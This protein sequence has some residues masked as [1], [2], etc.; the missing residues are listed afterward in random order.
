MCIMVKNFIGLHVN[1][2]YSIGRLLGLGDKAI[3]AVIGCGGKTTLISSLAKEYRQKKVLVT[4][5]T[6]IFP[7]SGED[8]TL[9]TIAQKCLSHVP[10]KGIQCLGVLNETT[11]KLEALQQEQLEKII[12]QYDLVL[13]E[14]DGSSGLPCKAWLDYEPVIPSYCTHTIGVVTLNALGKAAGTDSVHRL[15]EFLKLTCLSPDEAISMQALS[16]MVCAE[17]GMFKRSIGKQCIFVNQAEDEY[18][19]LAAANWLNE[20][21]TA[22]PGRFSCLAY[23]SALKNSWSEV[24]IKTAL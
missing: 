18:S 3:I 15:P 10:L 7:M 11:G 8:I 22:N 9:L 19:S 21:Q 23:G 24:C 20:I 5:T 1:E 14:A 16:A 13:L 6:K 2:F 12:P 17:N 4:P